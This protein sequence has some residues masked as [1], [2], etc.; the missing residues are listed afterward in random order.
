MKTLKKL[1][2][3]LICL[4]IV[5]STLA[6]SACQ[7]H[8]E[9]EIPEN[10][11]P[12]PEPENPS[13]SPSPEP[14]NPAP[15]EPLG[16]EDP[17]GFLPVLR[18]A[19]T[20]DVHVR[21]TSND[22]GSKAKLTGFVTG[23]YSYAASRKN[24]K[25][26]DGLF[27]VG[28]LTQ[29][30]K[31]QEYNISKNV[32]DLNVK[33]G[34]TLLVTM[35][36]HEMHAFGSGDAR[37]TPEN[38]AL[39]TERFR[40]AFGYESEDAHVVING[41][42]F[43]SLAN[44]S[45][46]TRNYFNDESLAW[47]KGEI[48]AAMAADPTD[49]KP[50]FV[51]QHEGPI[52]TVRGFT[53]GDTRLGELLRDYPRVVDFSGHTH[54]SILDPQSIWQDGFT[55]IGTGGLAY[56]G[57]NMA[58]HP[59]LDNSATVAIDNEGGYIGGGST[60]ERTGAMYYIVEV[61]AENNIRLR[62]YDLMSGRLYGNTITFKVGADEPEVFTPDRAERSVAPIFP[63]DAKIEMIS[64]DYNCPKI[65]F[66][67]PTG[68]D[69][70]QYY[71]VELWGGSSAEPETVIYR[72]GGMHNAANMP[73]TATVPIRG[74]ARSGE[75]TVKIYAVNCWAKES[76]PLT[77]SITVDEKSMTPD[78]LNTVFNIDG[79]AKNGDGASLLSLGN[80]SVS[81]NEELSRNIA[82]FDGESGYKFSGIKNFYDSIVY[83]ITYEAYFRVAEGVTE[84]VAIGSNNN[85]AGFGLSR[86]TDGSL[87]FS[88]GVN[89]GAKRYVYA[90]TAENTAKAGEW[91]HVVAALDG[92]N[93]KIYVN[94]EQVMLYNDEGGEIGK[95]VSIS[96]KLFD[97]PSGY[98]A[99]FVV[100]GDIKSNGMLEYGFVGDIAALNLYSR[101]LTA[102]EIAGLY[103]D[104][105]G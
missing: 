25:A 57:Y 62:I 13:P 46:E 99:A 89:N 27:I 14:E 102:E 47:L 44:D 61:D 5:L 36:N 15:E 85:S 59:T 18:F 100:G 63:T 19:I 11:S 40:N 2:Y 75:F 65:S 35:G 49:N 41:Y 69:L 55:A 93:I 66:T 71:R 86:R 48:E 9:P 29:D 73:K 39:S 34:T 88:F 103:S 45:Y 10:P 52:S 64:A 16:E 56:L 42:H 94:G 83:A 77:G 97:A 38:I 22:Y 51:M 54:R 37:F 80:V 96:G 26:L 31:T 7:K 72:L 12:S 95:A 98:A 84:S 50:I 79:T 91:V 67:T 70:V 81:Y 4:S 43:I 82:S 60:G 30:G 104:Y 23:A 3:I 32:L 24:Y 20:S 53:G 6:F 68:G 101:T 21:S 90:T 105:L 28:D 1:F 92:E 76:L 17:D 58:G 33:D 8:E 87:R 78:I 74:H